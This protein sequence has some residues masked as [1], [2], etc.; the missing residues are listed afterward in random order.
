MRKIPFIESLIAE[1][2]IKIVG[3]SEDVADSYSKKSS[4]SLR[5][6]KI[7]I[8]QNL[9]EEA[10]SMAYYAMYHKVTSIFHITGIKCENHSATII[11][12][13]ELFG[14]DNKDISFAKNERVDKQYY[15]DIELTIEEARTLIRLAESF[16]DV[17]E[18]F[19]DNLTQERK[20]EYLA[21]FKKS[22]ALK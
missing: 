12:L 17:V 18:L 3:P 11:L 16:L 10:I 13:T 8:E 7:L 15:T 19:L 4:N 6:A 9:A 20:K 2:K 14:V 1:G 21:D 5:A 22:Y